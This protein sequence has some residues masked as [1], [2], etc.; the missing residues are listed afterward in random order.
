MGKF[1]RLTGLIGLCPANYRKAMTAYI[2]SVA[3]F[4]SEL[5]WKWITSGEPSV[6]QTNCTCRSTRR[7]GN[8]RLFP[9]N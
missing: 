3:I 7:Q 1:H 4:R 6:R 8:N 5:W 2:Q 9:D